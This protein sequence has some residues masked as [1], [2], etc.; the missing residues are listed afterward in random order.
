VTLL[1]MPMLATCF[2]FTSL[3]ML[4]LA[5][6]CR[7]DSPSTAGGLARMKLLA[8]SESNYRSVIKRKVAYWNADRHVDFP[9]YFASATVDGIPVSTRAFGALELPSGSIIAA[10]PVYAA[11][12]SP[13]SRRIAPGRY[14]VDA[15]IVDAGT[16]GKKVAFVRIKLSDSV[17]TT[18][19]LAHTTEDNE[20]NTFFVVDSGVACFADPAAAN[21][22]GRALSAFNKS[23]PDSNYYDSPSVEFHGGPSCNHR[24][25]PA[26]PLNVIMFDSGLGNDPMYSSF[27]GLDSGGRAVW[28]VTDFGLFDGSGSIFRDRT[29]ST[30]PSR[31]P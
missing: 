1:R 29:C 21:L 7:R 23:H 9:R 25:D 26:S 20:L 12:A 18:W 13:F 11:K 30:S 6:G 14:P 24:P 22:L 2:R 8:E 4:L 19:E 5:N 15:S 28:L 10:D 31:P 17:P 27:W 16:W 3:A